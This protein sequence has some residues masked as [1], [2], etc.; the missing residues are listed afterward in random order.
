[1]LGKSGS[2]CHFHS[3]VRFEFLE[4]DSDEKWIFFPSP[5][6]NRIILEVLDILVKTNPS[7]SQ[8]WETNFDFYIVWVEVMAVYA[9]VTVQCYACTTER[10]VHKLLLAQGSLRFLQ[11]RWECSWGCFEWRRERKRRKGE[12]LMVGSFCGVGKTEVTL[13]SIAQ[14][15]QLQWRKGWKLS[16][17]KLF[18]LFFFWRKSWK[19]HPFEKIWP[20]WHG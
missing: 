18:S 20:I 14:I 3:T 11:A 5:A 13:D 9:N 2:Y 6:E 7:Y 15:T 19:T 12:I 4:C 8:T 16:R 1:M 10:W 17:L